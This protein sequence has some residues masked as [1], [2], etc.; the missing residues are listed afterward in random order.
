MLLYDIDIE[1]EEGIFF[2][3]ALTV[4]GGGVDHRN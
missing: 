1:V 3:I 2:V 4:L